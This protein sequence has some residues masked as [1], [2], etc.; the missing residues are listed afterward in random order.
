MGQA[1]FAENRT[2][3]WAFDIEILLRSLR[4]NA[5]IREMAVKII[6]HRESKIHLV[7]DSIRMMRDILKIRKRLK[8]EAKNK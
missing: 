6:N 7:K 1:V 4:K 8:E 5:V 2:W 3:G